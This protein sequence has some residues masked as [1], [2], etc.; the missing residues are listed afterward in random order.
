MAWSLLNILGRIE[1]PRRDFQDKIFP[2]DNGTY[3][4]TNFHLAAHDLPGLEP[5][6]VV[7]NSVGV[8]N[9]PREGINSF[10]CLN[11]GKIC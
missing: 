7:T 5:A 9:H 1:A 3:R 6:R 10:L 11:R 8:W 2:A 4:L